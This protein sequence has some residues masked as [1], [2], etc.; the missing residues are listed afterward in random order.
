M[1]RDRSIHPP[2]PSVCVFVYTNDRMNDIGIETMEKMV[3]ED[4]TKK[5][6][7]LLFSST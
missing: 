2:M 6:F 4:S 1:K 7:F 5:S 3:I